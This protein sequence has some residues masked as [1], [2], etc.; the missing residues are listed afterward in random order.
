MEP[1]P[2]PPGPLFDPV[3]AVP[4]LVEEFGLYWFHLL[5]AGLSLALAFIVWRAFVAWGRS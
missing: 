3:Q 4:V 2:F 5:S 1:L